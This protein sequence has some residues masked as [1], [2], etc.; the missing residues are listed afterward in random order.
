MSTPPRTSARRVAR[1][2]PTAGI[3]IVVAL[4]LGVLAVRVF[5][6]AHRPLSWAAAAVVVAV[7]LD[8]IV[9]RLAVHIK[10]VPAVLLCF[11]VA[12]A[13]VLGVAYVVFDDLDQAMGRLETAAPQAAERI[14]ERDDRVGQ[15][16]RDLH[17]GERID[18]AV[19]ALRGRVGSGG[20]VIRSTALSA[21]AYLVGAILT[22]F[23][24]S[25]GP[26]IGASALEQLPEER[27][28]RSNA[29]L[30]RAANRARSAAILTVA[31][32][33]VVGA[34]VSVV[35]ALLDLPAPAALGV[36]AALFAVLPHLGIVLGS[37]P[38]LLLALGLESG[39]AA[40]AIG[41]GAVALQAFDTIV[42]RK[43]IDRTVHLGLLTPWVVVLL[44]N[45]VYGVGAAAYGLAFA[46]FGLAVLDELS[47]DDAPSDGDTPGAL[48]ME[49]A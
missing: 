17:L 43:R 9:D 32:A 36:L 29:V 27:R 37:I 4:V 48:A 2:T 42:V 15:I 49:P 23:L 18:D 44:A 45:D 20:E 47:I 24:M 16:S 14:E 38:L 1:L 46:L 34:L 40:A 41:I 33:L 39:V 30:T 12:G 13:G 19:L 3:S 28:G 21:P 22:V 26:R 5:D 7:V 31:D 6:A 10:R 8:P 11:V 25:Y 35:A